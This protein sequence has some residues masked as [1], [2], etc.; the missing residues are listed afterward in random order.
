M[1]PLVTKFL[2]A[3]LVP[4]ARWLVKEFGLES[5]L[6]LAAARVESAVNAIG[7]RQKAIAKAKSLKGGRFGPVIIED[8]ARW[9]VYSGDL[10]RAVFPGIDGD[11]VAEMHD[12]DT[13]RLRTPDELNYPLARAWAKQRFELLASRLRRRGGDGAGVDATNSPSGVSSSESSDATPTPDVPAVRPTHDTVDAVEAKVG[14]RVF[15]AAIGQ[16]PRMLD[17]LT[18]QTALPVGQQE[19]IPAAPGIYVFSE[20]PTPLYVGN[21]RNLRQRLRQHTAVNSRENEAALAWRIALKDAKQRGLAITGTRKQIDA[22]PAFAEIFSQA[23]D[24]V[25][26]MDVRFI[27]IDDSIT[28]TLFEVYAAQALGTEEFNSFETH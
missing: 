25:R 15:D 20:G 10:P 24:R 12:Y 3:G 17:D 9:V 11:L 6:K 14:Q 27:E 7:E 21:T 23:R 19:G 18:R 8:R 2:Q 22:D 28:R 5:V 16:M 26:A 1:N 4:A 13:T